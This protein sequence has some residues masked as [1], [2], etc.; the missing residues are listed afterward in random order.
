[1]ETLGGVDAGIWVVK[2]PVSVHATESRAE[3]QVLAELVGAEVATWFGVPT[4]AIGLVDVPTA[5]GPVWASMPATVRTL[6]DANA[7]RVAFC[8]RFLDGAI[9]TEPGR[10][11]ETSQGREL[12]RT[13]G[14]R[15]MALDTFL[16]HRDRTPDRPNAVEW[17][18]RLVA[19]DHGGAFAQFTEK[20]AALGIITAPGGPAPLF[21][22][23][24]LCRGDAAVSSNRR[25]ERAREERARRDRRRD[26]CARRALAGGSRPRTHAVESTDPV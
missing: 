24:L 10:H 5:R 2:P 4:P 15:F 11:R 23:A 21:H 20:G 22:P 17:L 6:F 16:L 3:L 13:Y 9:E 7:G 18:G 1:M 25:P 8:S 12:L 26:R 19:I 14:A